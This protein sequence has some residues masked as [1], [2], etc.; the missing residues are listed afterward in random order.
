MVLFKRKKLGI[1]NFIKKNVSIHQI[2]D[3]CMY[4]L[5]TMNIFIN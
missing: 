1:N 3:E 5:L 2:L 4:V